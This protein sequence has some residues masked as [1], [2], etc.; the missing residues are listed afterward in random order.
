MK[1]IEEDYPVDELLPEYDF[2]R[3]ETGKFYERYHKKLNVALLE[4]DIHAMFPN[5]EAVNQALRAVAE[6]VKVT[7]NK[8]VV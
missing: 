1:K 2:S 8:I 7:K 5:S 4:P 6:L 3:G